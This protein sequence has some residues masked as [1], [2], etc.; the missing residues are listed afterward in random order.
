[1]RSV[2]R[3]LKLNNEISTSKHLVETT[4]KFSES[5]LLSFRGFIESYHHADYRNLIDKKLIPLTSPFVV[6]IALEDKVALII[7]ERN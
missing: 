6:L 5:I 1:M 3:P 7:E 2:R 4:F